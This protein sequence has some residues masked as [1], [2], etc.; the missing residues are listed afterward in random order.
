[1]SCQSI[2][3]RFRSGLWLGHS[4]VLVFLQP[5][6]GGLAGVFCPAAE[7]KCASVWGHQQMARHYPLGLFGRQQNIMDPFHSHLEA[8]KQPQTPHTTSTIFLSWCDIPVVMEHAS[9]KKVTFCLNSISSKVIFAHSR[10][11]G[12]VWSLDPLRIFCSTSLSKLDKRMSRLHVLPLSEACVTN[13]EKKKSGRP[14]P[15]FTPLYVYI[16][17]LVHQ[18]IVNFVQ[19]SKHWWFSTFHSK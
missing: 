19:S 16:H 8:A 2:S 12:G 6:R 15:L 1:M 17:P 11:Y 13:M 18:I 14:K 10:S 7:P 9:S 4:N 3:G 5:F